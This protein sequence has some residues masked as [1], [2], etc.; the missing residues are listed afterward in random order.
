M[1]N[2]DH[3][4][5][6]VP[7]ERVRDRTTKDARTDDHDVRRLDYRSTISATTPAKSLATGIARSQSGHA[8]CRRA[9]QILQ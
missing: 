3:M 2:Q 8:Q 5:G 4:P 7:A 6:T 9:A 1:I